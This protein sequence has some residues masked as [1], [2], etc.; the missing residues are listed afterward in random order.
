MAMKTVV[1]IAGLQE[2][3]VNLGL[4]SKAAARGVLRRVLLKAGQ[5]IAD[6]AK[7]IVH[8]D[9][10]ELADSITV[11]SRI[12]NTVGNAEYHSVMADGGTKEEAGAALRAARSAAPGKSFAEVQVGP[13][14]ARTKAD[15]IKRIVEEFGSVNRAPHPYMR[16]AWVAKKHEALEVI[17]R[18]LGGEIAKSIA[19]MNKRA[20]KKAGK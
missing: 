8:R 4:L 20:A 10:G 2:L 19:R 5:P 1:H 15:A 16:P 11:S 12:R 7:A 6:A 18:E 17:K 3:D 14:Q 13:A 9:T